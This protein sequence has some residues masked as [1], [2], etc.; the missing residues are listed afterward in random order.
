[1]AIRKLLALA[2]AVEGATG[3][4][5]MAYPPVVTLL[6]LGDRVSGPGIAV[7]RVAGIALLSLGLACWPSG[8][9]GG[10][11][12]PGHRALLTYNLLVALYLLGIGIRGETLGKLLWPAFALHAL[13]A[14]LLARAWFNRTWHSG[15]AEF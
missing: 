12:T 5:L 9:V 4:A 13:V 1:M 8:K 2:A 10:G 11:R 6:L 14:Y 3:L 7:G 15:A